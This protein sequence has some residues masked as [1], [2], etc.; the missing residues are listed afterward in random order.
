[1]NT[2]P[3]RE[4]SPNLP[5]SVALLKIS[6]FQYELPED[7]IA[8]YPLAQRDDS[9]LLVYRPGGQPMAESF[10]D[11]AQFLPEG[12]VLLMNDTRV[13]HARLLFHKPGGARVEVFCL[14]PV[15]PTGEMQLAFGMPSPV[16]WE[17]LI[18]NA[19]RWKS[20]LLEAATTI[21]GKPVTLSAERM[22]QEKMNPEAAPAG[23][24]VFRVK[25]SWEPAA[26]PFSVI[27]EHFGLVPL[28]PY[29]HRE[30]EESDNTRYQTLYARQQG[31]VA[32]PT[33]GLHF[34]D[35]TFRSLA[36]KDIRP[37]FL[38]LHVGAGTFRPVV[39]ETIGNHAMHAEPFAVTD[40]MLKNLLNLNDRKMIAVGT[41][42]T[43]TLESLYWLGAGILQHKTMNYPFHL[44]QWEPYLSDANTTFTRKEV[45]SAL[46]KYMDERQLAVLEGDTTLMIAPC[47]TFRMIDG[48]VTNFHQ[49]GSTLLL[50]IAAFLGPG[51]KNAY[52]FALD[53]GFRFLSYGD[54]C[55]YLSEG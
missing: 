55:L 46:I 25:L 12:S 26:I 30:A 15:Q 9:K 38:T 51:W 5:S 14:H 17:C 7:R 10:H 22:V 2:N 36:T 41:T 24:P 21:D 52:Q 40:E 11:L 1:M 32:A 18:G 28:P 53:H 8:L 43:R 37:H 42:T 47:Y 34:T 27:I 54:S 19:K 6:D 31:S 50:L 48:L 13:I 20:G 49:P 39:T 35:A 33:A 45:I 29:I 23:N 3:I 4:Q 16:D 44:D